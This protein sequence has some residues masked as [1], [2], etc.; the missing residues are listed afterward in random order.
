MGRTMRALAAALI[1]VSALFP[2]VDDPTPDPPPSPSTSPTGPARPLPDSFTITG[3][4]L[5]D[6]HLLEVDGTYYLYGTMYSCGFD[7][8][9]PGGP[10]CGFGVATS[11]DLEAWSPIRWLI[12][13]SWI[14][15]VNGRSWRWT[16]TQEIGSGCFN[17]RMVLRTWEPYAD[18]VPL[19]FFNAPDDRLA[20]RE[21]NGYYALG[22]NSLLGGCGD[23]AGPPNGSTRKPNYSIC[24]GWGDFS[25]VTNGTDR[26]SILCT[27]PN[28]RGIAQELLSPAGNGGTGIGGTYLFDAVGEV[29]TPAAYRDPATGTW[30]ATYNT[31]NCGYGAGCPTAYALADAQLGP[32]RAPRNT[33]EGSRPYGRSGLSAT[34]C[35]GQAR[36]ISILHGVAYQGIDTWGSWNGVY[37]N[38]TRASVHF[39]RI[40]Y[41]PALQIGGPNDGT[42]WRPPF[43]AWTCE[44]G[45]EAQR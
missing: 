15:P 45:L 37:T 11:T 6:G 14:N 20:G 17:P 30:V 16:C 42:P 10:F 13:H 33:G 1:A 24:T 40:G 18:N 32:W 38:Q 27:M 44:N 29:E 7:W 25:I 5:H 9:D 8:K 2:V 4:D 22:C 43:R 35:G 19:L 12:H 41:D 36:T 23:Q 31:P 3:V 39:E 26:P 21:V 34:S 28:Q